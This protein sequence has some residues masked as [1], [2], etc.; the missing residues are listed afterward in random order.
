MKRL[1]N[2][3]ITSG[4][5]A[6]I[7]L[8]LCVMLAFKKFMANI[9]IIGNK[10]AIL[11]RAKQQKKNIILSTKL[12]S[13][14]G[15]GEL[16]IINLDYKNPVVSG[17]LDKSNSLQQ[18][19][20]LKNSIELCLSKKFDAL[21]T[22]P[23]H[24]KI[25]SS[26]KIKFTGHTEYIAD[27]CGHKGNEV[28]LLSNKK[29]NVALATTHVSLK[30]VPS[31]VTQK[32]LCA[33]ISTLNDDLKKKFKIPYPK[34][35]VTGL[36][37]HSGEDG[38]FGDEEIKIIKPAICKMEKLGISVN[39]PIPADTAF[40]PKIMKKTDCYLAMYHD[41]GLA[42]FK[43]LTFGKGVNVTLGLPIIR[44]SVDHGTGLDIAGS[45]KID[46]SS[47]FESIKLAISLAKNQY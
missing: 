46:P 5:P 47:F 6:G 35:T 45:N 12:G 34:I 17:Q 21:I 41:Q 19:R 30:D 31:K 36:N 38:E 42:P 10:N 33:T 27:A 24:K 28:M 2:L 40:T 29:L 39:G 23:I 22:L 4:D 44:T 37:P 25:L 3:I 11:S 32:S 26:K 7:G 43:A 20:G 8:D 18:L 15:N 14:L 13:H 1:P 9:T 16:K